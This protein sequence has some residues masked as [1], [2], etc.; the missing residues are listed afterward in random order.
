MEE[1]SIHGLLLIDIFSAWLYFLAG[2]IYKH[3]ACRIEIDNDINKKRVGL[4]Y[5]S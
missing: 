4:A 3:K 5:A 1:K 2:V